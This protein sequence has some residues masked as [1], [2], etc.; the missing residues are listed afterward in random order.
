MH[1]TLEAIFDGSV[2]RPE[3]TPKLPPNTRCT[4]IVEDIVGDKQQGD[5]WSVLD[6]LAGTVE[7]PED[8][9]SEHDHYLY[10]SKRR[11]EQEGKPAA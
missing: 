11:E 9:A 3:T 5:A 7:A 8:W 6:A 4:I 10:G 1:E 2:F